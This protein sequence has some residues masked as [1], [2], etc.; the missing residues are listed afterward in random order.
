MYVVIFFVCK[1]NC[2]NNDSSLKKHSRTLKFFH[3]VKNGT[4]ENK[5]EKQKGICLS[6]LVSHSITDAKSIKTHLFRLREFETAVI[7][8]QLSLLTI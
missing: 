4:Y 1:N 3:A 5:K 8:E 6:Q 2:G 7:K